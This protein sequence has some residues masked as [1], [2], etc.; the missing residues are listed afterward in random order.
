MVEQGVGNAHLLRQHP[1]LS[2]QAML[3]KELDSACKYLLLA[4]L[5]GQTLAR[6]NG[7]LQLGFCFLP[8]GWRFFSHVGIY[9]SL[10][11]V[12]YNSAAGK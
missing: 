10:S 3:G 9:Q 2:V 11:I 7:W 4:F 5:H 6:R 12:A 1:H 8:H